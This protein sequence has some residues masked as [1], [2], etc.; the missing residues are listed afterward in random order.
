MERVGML[1]VL[2]VS[3]DVAISADGSDI[4]GKNY[5]NETWQ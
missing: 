4:R 5:V 2:E 1:F 3:V